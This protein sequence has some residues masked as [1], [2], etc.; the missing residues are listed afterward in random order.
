[1]SKK[2]QENINPIDQ[3]GTKTDLEEQSYLNQIRSHYEKEIQR[4]HEDNIDVWLR[5]V[6]WSD[7]LYTNKQIKKSEI[8]EVYN[9]ALT[10]C[11]KN[12][13]YQNDH[14]L[15]KIFIDY[16]NKHEARKLDWLSWMNKHKYCVKLGQF[17]IEYAKI[18]EGIE[19]P[20]AFILLRNALKANVMDNEQ[21]KLV[22]DY[23]EDL[24]DRAYEESNQNTEKQEEEKI[25]EIKFAFS[26]L[27]LKPDPNSE[28]EFQ[29]EEIRARKYNALY[30]VKQKEQQKYEKKIQDLEKRIHELENK[31]SSSEMATNTSIVQK[32]LPNKSD[33]HNN[34]TINKNCN[35]QSF[36]GATNNTTAF[37]NTNFTD[38][39][40][41]NNDT[42]D[43]ILS[44]DEEDFNNKTKTL[45]PQNQISLQ[46]PSNLL[47]T[48]YETEVTL[49]NVKNSMLTTFAEPSVSNKTITA[50]T[51]EARMMAEKIFN[52]TDNTVFEKTDV[53]TNT[54]PSISIYKDPTVLSE[55][56][57][58]DSTK[59]DQSI[60]LVNDENAKHENITKNINQ[61]GSMFVYDDKVEGKDR[62]PLGIIADFEPKSINNSLNLIINES[63]T[64]ITKFMEF[65]PPAA[66]T[67]SIKPLLKKMNQFNDQN[68]LE[69]IMDTT[70][71]KEVEKLEEEKRCDEEKEKLL[72]A[73]LNTT[74]KEKNLSKIIAQ[75]LDTQTKWS[76]NL[77]KTQ[78]QIK[79]E[80]VVNNISASSSQKTNNTGIQWDFIDMSYVEVENSVKKQKLE[81]SSK[82]NF[83]QNQTMQNLTVP[84]LTVPLFS[85]TEM[86]EYHET[87]SHDHSEELT[88]QNLQ[89]RF[90]DDY[91]KLYYNHSMFNKT[92]LN[93]SKV[94]IDQMIDKENNDEKED[95]VSEKETTLA[96]NDSHTVS[97][98]ASLFASNMDNSLS[99][100]SN[101][102]T[103]VQNLNETLMAAIKEPFNIDVK[104]K[105]LDKGP[106]EMLRKNP[107]FA[108][109]KV[110][111]PTIREKIFVSLKDKI[112]Y[113]IIKEIGKG[114]FAKI[115]LIERKDTKKKMALKV[116]KQATSWE[117]YITENLHER[118]KKMLDEKIMKVNV[119][120]S[121]IR[122]DQFIKYQDGC[123]SSMN[124][125]TYGSLLDLINFHVVNDAMYPMFPYWFV[126]YL[127]LEMLYIIQ[128]LHKANI[129]HADIKPDNLIVNSLP[130]SISYFDP[131]KT[132]CLVLIDFNRSI[133]L[134]L[135]GMNIEFEAKVDNKSLLIPEM[136]EKKPWS[137]Q[138]DFYGILCSIHCVV[139]KKYMKTYKEKDRNRF[140]GSFPRGYDKMFDRLFDTYLNVPSCN[141]FPD[142]D[143]K[144]IENLKKLFMSELTQ[145]FTKSK[146]YLTALK[147]HFHKKNV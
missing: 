53:D 74:D 54:L 115:Y 44:E 2:D 135:L 72:T 4:R 102:S 104:N 92:S 120:E 100:L 23:L 85:Q 17:Y 90:N 6:E 142:I 31:K 131:T 22:T 59:R 106:I 68:M 86:E 129:I 13:T 10:N 125:Y 130:D 128:Y 70:F 69:T 32:S 28:E 56:Q 55:T 58:I 81:H 61:D 40:H 9:Q 124:Y 62:R 67:R 34:F 118:L 136:K 1:M 103:T 121:F 15:L 27:M 145:S 16:I 119:M 87:F 41:F 71:D 89:Q 39:T 101:E 8:I 43:M 52:Q 140:V 63:T 114:A 96:E 133:D 25:N 127:T 29:F 105:L 99:I 14:R 7:Q 147:E 91:Y 20:K 132:K 77:Q 47:V 143:S 57:N 134:N 113:K 123:F 73:H 50:R 51:T 138:V 83:T 12:K 110:K 3:Q 79:F 78:K 144:F 84:N 111:A 49:A 18:L 97:T 94:M 35:R 48:N 82:L 75:D 107:N 30:E 60:P 64:S 66:S 5:Y 117:F 37:N 80:M 65:E 45:R 26:Y 11:K 126:L 42:D 33:H 24:R 109:L 137:F 112:D 122:M 36:L 21:S 46:V 76:D 88:Q 38:V 19:R 98:K 108:T 146:K 116:D 139:F 95:A 93:V 141:E